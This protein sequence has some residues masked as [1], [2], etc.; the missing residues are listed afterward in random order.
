MTLQEITQKIKEKFPE[1]ILEEKLDML[2]PHVVVKTEDILNI[3][4]FLREDAALQFDS[5]MC[6]SSIDTKADFE[7]AYSL[8]S[9]TLRHR[10]G[11]KVKAP[12]E[13]PVVP[14]VEGLWKTA[15]WHEREAFDLMGITFSGHPNLTRI[16]CPE[17]W[18]G[19][20]LRKDYK[21]PESYHDIPWGGKEW[22]VKPTSLTK[23]DEEVKKAQ[24]AAA[25]AQAHPAPVSPPLQTPLP[26]ENK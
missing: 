22:Q 3:C 7:V 26:P 10:F 25:A 1:S 8:F 23:Q 4:K 13:N 6:L 19:H 20:P 16:L 12:R 9:Y 18:V 5:L 14:S 15:N 11:L 17:D 2:E 24:S 21:F